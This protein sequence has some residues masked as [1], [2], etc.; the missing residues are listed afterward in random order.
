MSAFSPETASRA[1]LPKEIINEA[2]SHHLCLHLSDEILQVAV[3]PAS[4]GDFLW[5]E[6]FEID[7]LRHTYEDAA[8]FAQ[9]RNWS[10]KIFR[11]CSLTFDTSLFT[12]VPSAFFDAS[13][14]S[15]L[16]TFQTGA[17]IFSAAN[18]S[19]PEIAAFLVYEQDNHVR[20]L[21]KM[22]PNVRIFPLAYLFVKHA[23]LRSERHEL[24]MHISKI[25]S[26]MLLAVVK[27]KKLILINHFDVKNEEDVLYHASNISLRLGIDFE[28]VELSLYE[29][30]HTPPLLTLLKKYNQTTAC[31]FRNDTKKVKA[32]FPA[33]LHVLCA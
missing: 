14:Q 2:S 8:S 23:L 25:G 12:P 28:R 11:K 1:L 30:P 26:H 31:A 33:Y 27:N 9:G 4:G 7:P 24:A 32:S 15:E 3:A 16:L 17:T 29:M 5:A 6:E 10:D 19:L 18:L 13:K 21:I 20:S 22:F